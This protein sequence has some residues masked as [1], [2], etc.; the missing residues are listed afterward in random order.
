MWLLW[1]FRTLTPATTSRMKPYYVMP[2]KSAEV[3]FMLIFAVRRDNDVEKPLY[4]SSGKVLT[5]KSTMGVEPLCAQTTRLPNRRARH[6][7][8]PGSQGKSH[9]SFYTNSLVF[10]PNISF[11]KFG[12]QFHCLCHIPL[13][14]IRFHPARALLVPS[15]R[16]FHMKYTRFTTA[17]ACSFWS[18]QSE[19]SPH[20]KFDWFENSTA[21][22][23]ENEYFLESCNHI[24]LSTATGKI[25]LNWLYFAFLGIPNT[26]N[27][28]T[29][30]F[31]VFLQPSKF[32]GRLTFSVATFFH[33]QKLH[34]T[35]HF[36]VIV[37]SCMPDIV[38]NFMVKISPRVTRVLTV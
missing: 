19:G 28:Q 26:P 12:I 24:A 11:E 13:R 5:K 35:I 29:H 6:L 37:L 36:S 4:G 14:S 27:F 18:S 2:K 21:C 31:E 22:N 30:V 17:E 15:P 25:G 16:C 34:R 20:E 7:F 38:R 1:T 33:L 32:G 9:G 10:F 8:I 23:I 3:I